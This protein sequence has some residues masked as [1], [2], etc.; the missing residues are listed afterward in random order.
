MSGMFDDLIREIRRLDG[1]HEISVPV[2]ADEKGYIDK[3]CPAD[4]CRFAFKVRADDWR[5]LFRDDAVY[6][7]RCGHAAP[8][9]LVRPRGPGRAALHPGAGRSP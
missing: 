4:P 6:C 8:S 2:A 5:E 7:P 9:D 3:E 1:T